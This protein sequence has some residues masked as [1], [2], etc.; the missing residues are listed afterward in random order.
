MSDDSRPPGGIDDWLWPVM[1]GVAALSGVLVWGAMLGGA[2]LSGTTGVPHNP[3]TAILDLFFDRVRWPGLPADGVLAGELVVLAALIW[4]AL[5]AYTYLS[6]SRSPADKAAYHLGRGRDLAAYTDA[7]VRQSA[8]RLRHSGAGTDPAGHGM[9]LGV[10][11]ARPIRTIRMDWESTAVIIAGPRMGKTTTLVIRQLIEAPGAA[12]ITSVRRDVYD[13]TACIRARWGR[14][15][16]FDPQH[17]I[18]TGPPGWWFDPFDSVRDIDGARIL[19]GHFADA[20]RGAATGSNHDYFDLEGEHLLACLLFAASVKHP[21]QRSLLDVVAWLS[22]SDSTEPI[23]L[24]EA[25]RQPHASEALNQIRTIDAARQK[26]GIYGFAKSLLSCLENPRSIAWVTP[27]PPGVHRPKFDA[28]QFVTSHDTLYLHAEKKGN[29]APL[30]AALTHAVH[31][32]GHRLATRS[33][34]ARLDPPLLSILDE[35]ANIC[36]LRDL[37]NDYSTLGG[38]GMPTVTVLQSPEQGRTVWGRAGFHMLWHSA[39][40]NMYLGGVA[41]AAFLREISDLLGEY[42]ERIPT[43]SY[44]ASGRRSTSYSIYRRPI[45]SVSDLAELPRGRAVVLI[46]GT[47][48]TVIRTQPWTETHW[49]PAIRACIATTNPAASEGVQDDGPR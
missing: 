11:I 4:G 40:V 7:G 8:Q 42:E 35:A 32:A 29:L 37:P 19:A 24:L 15:W 48:S 43:S 44:D 47:R 36:L 12:L 14:C 3:E 10:T 38:H 27:P 26:A 13:A 9:Y 49:A 39:T 17:L 25:A 34:D 18:T 41:D 28:A 30:V 2:A 46:S 6:T 31:D 45:M 16:N 23:M 5:R 22:Q 21:A 1:F 20:T 33:P